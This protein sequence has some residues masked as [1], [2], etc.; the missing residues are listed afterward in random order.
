MAEMTS[1]A[2]N[3]LPDSA[4][5][6]IEP[7]GKV[8]DGKTEPRSLRHFP[9]HDAAHVRN[10]MARMNQSPFG[11]EAKAKIMAAAKKMG[12]GMEGKATELK[13]E[14]MDTGRL[15]RWLRGMIPR[16]ILVAPFYGP[17]KAGLFGFPED[18]LGRDVQGEYFHPET[19]FYGP[20]PSLRST[21]QR[22]V[23]WHHTTFSPGTHQDPIGDTMKAAIIGHL[24]LDDATEDDGLWADFWA[25]AGEK[26]R[27]L[28][29]D[30][31][32][33]GVALYGSTQPIRGGVA[34]ADFG[35]IDVWPIQYHTIS[36]SPV[37]LAAVV[38]PLKA[39]LTA[40]NLDDVPADALKALLLGLDAPTAELLLGSVDAA[41][42]TSALLGSDGGKAG[43]VLSRQTIADLER[44]LDLAERELPALIRAI[45]ARGQPIQEE[46][47]D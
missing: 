13:A 40:P 12:I 42:P 11:E 22:A 29:A 47:D 21:R 23:D 44:V 35:R 18:G 32:M 5:A 4:F 38:P 7:G 10:A 34:K 15:E 33:R 24:V 46:P 43:R 9:I 30:L 27:K 45:V 6:Y 2:I 8:V 37:N 20:Y 16:R 3:D 17:L 36:T 31:E 19:D 41:V 25:N 14:P 1:S 26:R 28:I 39:F